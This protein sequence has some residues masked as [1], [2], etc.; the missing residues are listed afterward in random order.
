MH[1][2]D[3]KCL[4]M[5]PDRLVVKYGD[6]ASANCTPATPEPMGWEATQGGRGLTGYPQTLLEWT[7]KKLT[8]Y[9]INPTC[10]L[11]GGKCRKK[12]NITVYKP[13]A[14]VSMSGPAG[15][16]V[17]G[18]LYE[19][20]CRV[21][22]VA[23]ASSL[24]VS[25][26]KTFIN[27]SNI[28]IGSNPPN[29][30]NTTNTIKGPQSGEYPLIFLPN[31][32]DDG[33]Q[34]WCSARLELGE[35]GPQPPPQMD[36]EHLTLSVH[37]K[38]QVSMSSGPSLNISE[39][40]TLSLLCQADGNPAPSYRWFLITE[41]GSVLNINTTKEGFVLSIN[42]TK[43]G[44]ELSINNI[45]TS[46]AGTYACI[47]TNEVGNSS[48]TVE[49]KVTVEDFW[50]AWWWLI[51]VLV[52]TLILMGIFV[53]TYHFYYKHNRTGHYQLKDIFP[54]PCKKK[55]VAPSNG[56]VQSSV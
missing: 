3:A 38:P 46:L 6:P 53:L 34:L 39:G 25:F 43:K 45:A 31:R 4:T 22:D 1:A 40:H 26:Y 44:S 5:K 9:N 27:S 21:Q 24:F 12:L 32:G 54:R 2:N 15:P 14:N 48:R 47:A 51:C 35:Q 29:T 36:S 52:I 41:K 8:D 37:Y 42:T 23:P 7:V 50:K 30:T 11:E 55:H 56:M 17:E 13:P 28:E 49:V 33:A 19:F 16:M 20:R 10:F 18:K